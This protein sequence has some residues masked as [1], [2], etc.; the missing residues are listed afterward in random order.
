MQKR[1]LLFIEF[2]VFNNY[3]SFKWPKVKEYSC[4]LLY[5]CQHLLSPLEELEKQI[6]HFYESL[7][8]VNEIIS[9]LD[10]EAQP[11]TVLKQK[12]Q[13]IFKNI[14]KCFAASEYLQLAF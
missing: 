6:T 4:A 13:V 10:P 2:H 3:F 8:K 9:I 12:A 1:K 7:E 14:L 5:E 11:T